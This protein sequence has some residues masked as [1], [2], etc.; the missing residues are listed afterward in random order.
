MNQKWTPVCVW[1]ETVGVLFVRC[2]GAGVS[3][4]C[5]RVVALVFV[6]LGVVGLRV[7]VCVRG[8]FV[9]G[10]SGLVPCVWVGCLCVGIAQGF[11][12]C[13]CVC[14]WLYVLFCRRLPTN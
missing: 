7:C 6:G 11:V 12:P 8:V 14:G 9:L 13:M 5:M 4:V 1:E 10:V 3:A 2:R